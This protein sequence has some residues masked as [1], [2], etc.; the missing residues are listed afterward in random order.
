MENAIIIRQMS[1]IERRRWLKDGPSMNLTQLQLCFALLASYTYMPCLC[2]GC[3]WACWNQ[4][5]ASS[6]TWARGV[7]ACERGLVFLGPRR[8][9]SRRRLATRHEVD[10]CGP[11]HVIHTWRLVG[12]WIW[13]PAPLNFPYGPTTC[14]TL[15]VLFFSISAFFLSFSYFLSLK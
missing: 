15:H 2:H 7:G 6:K 5:W 13:T 14:L 3:T 12:V 4:R 9:M 10:V 8:V 1:N 11:L